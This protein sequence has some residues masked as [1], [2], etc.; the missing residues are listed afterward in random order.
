MKGRKLSLEEVLNLEDGSIVWVEPIGKE[1]S[2]YED[3]YVAKFTKKKDDIYDFED[4]NGV[5]AGCFDYGN[6]SSNRPTL[7]LKGFEYDVFEYIDSPQVIYLMAQEI[8]N[9]RGLDLT[10]EN[11]EMII[12]EFS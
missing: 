3:G 12:K 4:E 8:C 1:W 2:L 11:I 7:F 10:D 9:L 5:F 6:V